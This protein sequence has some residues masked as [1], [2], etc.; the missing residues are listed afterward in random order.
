MLPFNRNATAAEEKFMKIR[1]VTLDPGHFHAALVQK[2]M[3][4]DVDRTVHVYGPLGPDLLTHAERIAGFNARN[5]QPTGWQLEVH[6]RTDYLECLLEQKPGNVVILAGR[7]IRK[8][9][10][11]EAAVTAGL[12]VLADKPWIVRSA[13]LP[14]L[15]AVLDQAERR[16]LIACDIMTERH[17]ITSILQREFVHDAALFGA[18]L[19]GTPDE[20]GIF[21]ESVHYLKKSVAGV[22]L[23]R[24][25][26]FFSID[27]QGEGLSDVGT[28]LVDLAMWLLFPDQAVAVDREIRIVAGKRWPTLL[29]RGDF[30][31]I[32][33]AADFPGFLQAQ[34][35]R[36][37]LPF[38]CNNRVTYTL[39]N[40]HV[41]LNVLWD[42]EAAPGSGDSHVAV[43][44]GTKAS[45]EIRQGQ[46]EKFVPELYIVPQATDVASAVQHKT[47][48]LQSRFPGIAVDAQGSRMR[49]VI[50]DRYRVG[51]EAHFAEVTKQFL[52][53]VQKKEA[54]PAWEKPN[55]LAKYAVTTRGVEACKP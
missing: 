31:Q 41:T 38:F 29:A 23:R 36:D 35:D 28:H 18:P 10:Y 27:E 30:Q 32:T 34:L 45:V 55:M 21:M 9:G 2:E 42:L 46:E 39:R 7:N 48:A 47:A 15:Q 6:A 25:P 49:I 51:H 3:Y 19:A 22:P 17:E 24:P 26:W 40:I 33:G 4:A 1:F 53:Y 50:P 14:R 16:G 20:P 54:L 8:I 52:G 37:R 44:R 11:L 5:D 43:V 13:D 12:N